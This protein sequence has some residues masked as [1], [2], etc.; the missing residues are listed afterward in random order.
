LLGLTH[1]QLMEGL[2]LQIQHATD[3]GISKLINFLGQDFSQECKKRSVQSYIRNTYK[4]VASQCSQTR[5][6]QHYLQLEKSSSAFHK[7]QLTLFVLFF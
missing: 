4:P 5:N 2:S 1:V 6:V 7:Q 3:T